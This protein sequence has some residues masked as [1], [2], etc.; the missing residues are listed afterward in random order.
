MKTNKIITAWLMGLVLALASVSRA[1]DGSSVKVYLTAKDTGQRLARVADLKFELLPQPTEQQQCVFVDGSARFQTLLGIGGALTDASAETFYKLPKDKQQEL[2]HAYFEPQSG[3]GYSLGRTHINSCDFSS[4]MYDYIKEGDANLT[5]FDI[6]H[7]QKYRIPFIKEAMAAA[8]KDFSL[9]VSPWSPPAWMKSNHDMLHGGS[10]LPQ[11]Y[12]AWA[13]YYAKF[14]KTY[15]SQGIPIWG[16]TVQNEP[17]ANQT[18]E[19]CIYTAKE[20]CDFVKILGPTLAKAGLQNKKL[21]VWD[22]NRGMMFQRAQGVLDDP[23]AAQY[24]W[25]VGFHWYAGD[26]FENVKRVKEVYPNINVLLTEACLYP[27]DYK[28]INEWQW[29]ETYAKSMINDFNNGA[30][31]WTDWNVLLDETGGP[32]HVNNFCYAPVHGDIKTGELHYMNSY[33]YIGHF[34]KFIRPGAKRI[35]S[36]ATVDNLMTTA[37]VNPNGDMAVVVLNAS[38]KEQ[39]FS[40][41]IQGQAAKTTSPAH[42]IMTL[43][44]SGQAVQPAK[45]APK[46]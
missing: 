40:L 14:I 7:D 36:S 37:F 1:D 21:L 29:G 28:K 34:S 26:N 6:S 18:W 33:Y 17:M 35:V 42:S 41:W 11:F 23:V 8:G 25:G 5:S 24:V 31:G 13:N 19:S 9:F 12:G 27:F 15:E 44:V 45:N 10:L 16:L 30:V 4:E 22:H 43:M 39:L 46:K 38:D 3:I 20:E 2:I 32:N